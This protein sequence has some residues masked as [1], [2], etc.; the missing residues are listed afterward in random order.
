MNQQGSQSSLGSWNQTGVSWFVDGGLL[1]VSSHHEKQDHRAPWGPIYKDTNPI[2]EG[3]DLPKA[4]HPNTITFRVRI[5]TY[6]FGG[7]DTNIQSIEFIEHLL[8][9]RRRATAYE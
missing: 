1:A 5:S 8:C 4:L 9:A 6:K 3:G 2:H 7:G